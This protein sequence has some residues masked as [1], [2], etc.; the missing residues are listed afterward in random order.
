[1]DNSLFKLV[2]FSQGSYIIL[3]GER[4]S[5]QFYIIKE[6]KVNLIK[7]FPVAG[8]K[9]MEVL[10]SG[11]F[12][13]VIAAMSQYPQI[14]SAIALTNVTLIAVSHT[15]FGEL[16]QKNSALAMKIIRYFSKKLRQFDEPAGRTAG[17]PHIGPAGA[18]DLEILFNLAQF[19]FNQGNIDSAV[20]LYQSYLKYVLNGE[21]KLLAE[22]QLKMLGK[23]LELE[24]QTGTNRIYQPEQMI[25]CENEPGNDLFIV[26]RGK[27]RISKFIQNNDVI[28]NIMKPGD[29]FGEMALLDN[30]PRSASA[31]AME[32]V[33]VIAINKQN[34]EMMVVSQPQLMTKIIILL[35]ERIW[36]AYKKIANSQIPD[37]NG[38]IGDM[39]M[40]VVERNRVKIAPRAMYTFDMGPLELLKML[41]LSD[42]EMGALSKFMGLYKFLKIDG[43]NLVCTD[44]S[45][46]DRMVHQTRE[47]LKEGK[48]PVARR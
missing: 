33:E 14:E 13:G 12:F 36:N 10:G 22:K 38:R 19:Y 24:T 28:L 23:P 2:N 9:P 18:H 21:N 11:D 41:G 39:L 16:I 35:S 30:K 45:L 3:E 32:Q 26:Q 15:R 31:T 4:K 34:F 8:E 44:L 46:L 7:D 1:M 42:R 37:I 48:A 27:V 43:E 29:V 40:T 20:Y 47:H 17:K 6:G 25:F 5:T